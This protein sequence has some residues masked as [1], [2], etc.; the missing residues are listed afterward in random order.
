MEVLEF[1]LYEGRKE[2]G[3]NAFTFDTQRDLLVQQEPASP[4]TT[5]N[6]DEYLIE[7]PASVVVVVEETFEDDQ[8]GAVGG[9]NGAV[10]GAVRAG[11]GT[12][13]AEVLYWGVGHGA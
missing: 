10:A 13:W 11:V 12:V 7:P 8:A 3:I 9:A 6:V 1:R 4:L 5:I 2:L